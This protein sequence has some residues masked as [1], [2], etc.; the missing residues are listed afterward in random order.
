MTPEYLTHLN[1]LV[2]REGFR[3]HEAVTHDGGKDSNIS[4]RD[5]YEV[6]TA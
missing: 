1:V 6:C 4:M 2:E 3:F 5:V